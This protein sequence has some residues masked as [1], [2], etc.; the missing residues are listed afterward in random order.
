MMGGTEAFRL[1]GT[2]GV[3]PKPAMQGLDQ[4][5][6]HVQKSGGIIQTAMGTALGF[7]GGNAMTSI[8][9]NGVGFLKGAAIDYNA[10]MEQASI[11]FTTLLGSAEKA[12]SF[13]ADLQKFAATTP[14]DFPSLQ[15]SSNQLLAMGF[16]AEEV[17][18]TLTALGDAVAALGGGPEMIGRATQALGKMKATGKVTGETMMQL[19]EMGIPAWKLLAAEMGVTVTEAQKMVSDGLVPAEKGIAAITKGIESGDMGGMMAA[20]SATFNGA[21]SNISDTVN[22]VAG[23]ALSPF[24]E[25]VSAGA[26]ALATWMGSAE[27]AAFFAG[28]SSAVQ[29]LI[30]VLQGLISGVSSIVQGF[31]G[32]FAAGAPVK[33]VLDG[34]LTSLQPLIAAA[35]G[36]VSAIG[37]VV[38]AFTTAGPA[39][40]TFGT[41]IGNLGKS[42]G[43]YISTW[44]STV[45]TLLA[46]LASKFIAWVGP[47]VPKVVTALGNLG[48]SL[49][50]WVGNQIPPLLASLAKWAGSFIDWVGPQIPK[51]LGKLL[52]FV[53]AGVNWIVNTGLPML[54]S[55]MAKMAQELVKWVGPQ[56]PKLLGK[57]ADLMV[58]LVGWIVNTGLPR[59]L[60]AAAKLGGALVKGVIDLLLGKGGQPGLV[61]SFGT[62]VTRDLVPGVVAMGGTLLSA[63]VKLGGKIVTG[64]ID[65][66][67]SL[68]RKIWNAVTEAFRSLRLDIGPFHVSSSGVT[69]DLP[70]FATGSWS[71]PNTGPA[72]V[73][74]G[75]MIIPA[76]VASRLRNFGGMIGGG[77]GPAMLASGG[78]GGGL[79][80]QVAYTNA[81]MIST[82]SLAETE[83]A[84]NTLADMV[85]G[86]L[87]RRGYADAQGGLA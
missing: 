60:S 54:V 68:T 82:A 58:S 20:Q 83:Q 23:K 38:G 63:A 27:G 50:T 32:L 31:M 87:V 84:A 1:Y 30:G 73:H 81:P 21:M 51:F 62:F 69:I 77:G 64:V 33:T 22:Q 2:V 57:V 49:I 74:Q 8:I 66:L 61:S 37:G 17:V 15:Q 13:I 24:F 70:K 4:L 28:I 55:G 45:P 46:S 78:G 6:G 18:P 34:I 67:A 10:S 39:S 79:V 19:S 40:A 53:D 29:G 52:D 72:I 47:M 26:Q 80:I 86:I 36:I 65:G 44:I 43:T 56:V 7:L 48:R 9:S 25:M 85:V 3:D 5:S 16:S 12:Q 59:L 35:Q 76:D 41:A 42:I 71:V 14:F 75:E 11:G